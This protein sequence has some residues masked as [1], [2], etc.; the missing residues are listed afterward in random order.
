MFCACFV[1][2]CLFPLDYRIIQFFLQKGLLFY[3]EVTLNRTYCIK[4]YNLHISFYICNLFLSGWM[5]GCSEALDT[6]YKEYHLQHYVYGTIGSKINR[7]NTGEH[8]V[9]IRQVTLY[10]ALRESISG[11]GKGRPCLKE[12]HILCDAFL[13]P[14]RILHLLTKNVISR[15]KKIKINNVKTFSVQS[16]F[17]RLGFVL[18]F[19]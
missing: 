15:R 16:C 6:F 2:S 5:V 18:H 9:Y 8:V 4:F 17:Q 12:K 11:R 19:L 7:K 3:T 1:F 10:K 14:P 13:P